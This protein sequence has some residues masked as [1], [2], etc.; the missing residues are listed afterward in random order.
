MC[1]RKKC[2]YITSKV[3]GI[4]VSYGKITKKSDFSNAT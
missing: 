4:D 2:M 1:M 3:H